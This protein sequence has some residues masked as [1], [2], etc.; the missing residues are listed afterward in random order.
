ML[1]PTADWQELEAGSHRWYAFKYTGDGSQIEIRLLVEPEESLDLE[2]W[3]PEGVRR[4][5]LGLKA[6]PVGRGSADPYTNGALSWSGCFQVA[7][8]YY[9]VV[10]QAAEAGGGSGTSS[11]LLEVHGDGVSLV[12]QG[13]PAAATPEPSKPNPVRS[14]PSAPSGKLVFQTTWGGPFYVIN[15]D[16]TGLRLITDGM[17]PTWSPDGC[18]IA[19]VRWREPR[20][21]WV[22]H[23][24]SGDE[25]RAFDWSETRWPSWSPDGSRLLFSRQHGGR[26]EE[27]ERCFWGFCFT[28]P[29]HPHW[30]LS[31]IGLGDGVFCEPQGSQFSL[32]PEWSPWG[33]QI[34]YADEQG[35]RVQSE[36]DRV[37]YLITHNP[38]DT[39]PTW[40]PDGQWIAFTRRQHDHWEIYAVDADRRNPTRLTDTPRKPGGEVGNSAAPAWSPDGQ[41]L[42]FLT[43]RGGK[44]EIWIMQA[45]GSSQQ[46]M[47]E[48]TLDGL[49]LEYAH[50]GERAIS[51]TE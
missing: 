50:L 24:E 34:V 4:W 8:T 10:R 13:P 41:Y 20:G 2:V 38:T 1:A 46:P 30:K 31:V 40:S 21:L 23:A 12:S 25:W 17:D 15:A 35:L 39:G 3:T 42:A 9:A 7:G 5:R 45:N 51:W 27:R 19:F 43:D 16:G 29:P 36:V 26:L 32:A 33:E 6:E 47:F 37:A 22:V 14:A 49:R 18:Q 44:W 11:Y 28:I 48:G